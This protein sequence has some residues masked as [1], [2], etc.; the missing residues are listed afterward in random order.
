MN[1]RYD[2]IAFALLAFTAAFSAWIGI[3]GPLIEAVSAKTLYEIGKDYGWVF[4]T[5]IAA[6][7]LGFVAYQIKASRL[8][9]AIDLMKREEDRIERETFGAEHALNFLSAFHM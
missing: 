5:L 2:L 7:G 6:I 3:A 8:A 4:G 1:Q 9:L